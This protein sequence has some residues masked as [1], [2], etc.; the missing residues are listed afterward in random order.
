M[1]VKALPAPVQKRRDHHVRRVPVLALMPHSRCNCRCLMC[2]IWKGNRAGASLPAGLVERLTGE[3]RDL[4]VEEILLSGGE[5]MMHADLWSL[6]AMLKTLPVRITLLSTGLLLARHAEAVTRWCDEVIVSLDG[7]ETVHDAIR[8]VPRAFARLAQ[9]VA[10]LRAIRPGF[11]VSGRCV[12]QKR[13]FRDLSHIV[14][15]AHAIGL[16]RIS[17][18]TADLSSSAFNRPEAWDGGHTAA[19]CLDADESGEF[20]DLIEILIRERPGD[21]ASGFIAER[22]DRLRQLGDYYL[23]VHGLRPFPPIRCTAPWVSTVIE[24]DGTVRP[25]FFHAPIGNIHAATLEAILNSENAVAF[26]RNLDMRRD[27]VCSR[28]V[29]TFNL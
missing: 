4:G 3:L 20:L 12:L 29:C 6:C 7:S 16:D 14:S 10:A 11:P 22:P 15:A 2:D 25:C 28:C 5:P 9:G 19:V 26:R 8:G 21:F 17:F 1:D 23:A 24:A 18:L 13:N 27:P